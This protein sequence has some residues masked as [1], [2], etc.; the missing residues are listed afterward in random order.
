MK[1]KKCLIIKFGTAT[2]TDKE[3]NLDLQQLEQ[4]SDQIA[5]LMKKYNLILVSSGAVG[6][7]KVLMKNYTGT[8]SDRK[9]AAA[10]GNPILIKSYSTLL[11]KHDVFVAQCLLERKHF[12]NRKEF[13]QL[14]ETI[15]NIWKNGILPIANEND[16]V[17][18][19]ELKF[20]DNDEL[21]TL[22]AVS[23]N[24]DKLLIGSSVN[25]LLDAEN[26]NIPEIAEINSDILS[27]IKPEKT[28]AGLG[29]MTSKLTYAKQA[30]SLG[31]ETIIFNAREKNGIKNALANKTG[32]TFLPKKVK[33]N[34]GQRWIGSGGL[35]IGKIIIDEG[36]ENALLKRKSLLSVGVQ[37][38]ETSFSKGEVIEI[39]NI[40]GETIAFAKAKI[41]G[42]DFNRENKS[43]EVAHANEII[44][45]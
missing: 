43:I 42:E 10:I 16:V 15:E 2:L 31:I 32:T 39:I 17:S 38:V 25:G 44:L 26:K 45:I 28:S 34:A 22:L 8:I 3:G 24:A 11:E 12:S 40:S 30:T 29:G 14:R 19:L 6:T 37:S 36:A 5:D 23:F 13:L 7:G 1:K 18:D 9:A 21:A 27:F 41:N 35:K 20:S 33:L 4:V